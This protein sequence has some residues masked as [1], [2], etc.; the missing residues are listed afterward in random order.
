MRT[1]WISDL[2]LGSDNCQAKPAAAPV[3]LRNIRTGWDIPTL[4]YSD[5]ASSS[6]RATIAV[7]HH[8]RWW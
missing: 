4:T 1:A 5:H 8:D 7:A 6:H 2:H 3:D